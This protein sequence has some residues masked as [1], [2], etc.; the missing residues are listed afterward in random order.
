M[1]KNSLCLVFIAL[2]V[3]SCGNGSS[4]NS[5]S[6]GGETSTTYESEEASNS[7]NLYNTEYEMA[8]QMFICPLCQGNKQICHYYTGEI[9][10]CPGCQGTGEVT[11]ETIR[12]MQEA[13]QMGE[14]IANSVINGGGGGNYYGGYTRSRDDIERELRQCELEKE[15]IED[16]LEY[17]ESVVNQSYLSSQRTIL[18]TKINQLKREL[19]YAE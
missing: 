17:V 18:N 8:Q 5:D 15:G 2:I 4:S 10:E 1:K 7:K 16:Q 19:Q 13:V 14:D 12:Q 11:A 6:Y 3:S 9:M